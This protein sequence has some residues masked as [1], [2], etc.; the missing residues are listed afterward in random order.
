MKQY[1]KPM[2]ELSNLDSQPL[3]LETSEIGLGGDGDGDATGRRNP[4]APPF[5]GT[6]FRNPFER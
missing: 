2:T 4:F 3:M 6:P 1:L 5:G